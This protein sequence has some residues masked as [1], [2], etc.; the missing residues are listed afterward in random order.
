M[1]PSAARVCVLCRGLTHIL[2]NHEA[3]CRLTQMMYRHYEAAP[4]LVLH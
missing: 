3:S 4:T 2:P 1:Y